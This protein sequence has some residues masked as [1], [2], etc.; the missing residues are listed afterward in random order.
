MQEAKMSNS[1]YMQFAEALV[2]AHGPKAEAE[3]AMH[4]ILCEKSG[5][6]ETAETWRRV[7]SA[8]RFSDFKKAA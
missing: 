7:Q 6:M 1:G 4:A 8:L 5:D 2:F 3:A